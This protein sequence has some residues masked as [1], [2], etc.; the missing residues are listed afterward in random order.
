MEGQRDRAGEP[1]QRADR[2][3]LRRTEL[4]EAA[5]EAI[6]AQGPGAT[7]EQLANAGGVTKPILYRHFGDRDGLITA[8]AERFA[9]DLMSEIAAPLTAEATGRELLRSTIDAYVAFIERDP[10][11][12]R[13]LVQQAPG[14]AERLTSISAL[15]DNIA[16]Q[17]AQILRERL[18]SAGRDTGP[19]VAWAYG[20]VGLVHQAGDWW[21]DDQTMTRAQLVD[22]LTMLLWDGISGSGEPEGPAA[23]AAAGA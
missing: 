16:R 19:A 1:R 20:I 11:L 9:V 2:R 6:R 10:D 14:R 13:F 15:V 4:L 17:V 8:I 5:V 22:Q 12:Y 3:A 18:G 23:G 7:M 21:V